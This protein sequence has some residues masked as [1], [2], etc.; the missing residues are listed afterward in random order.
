MG[1]EE[2]LSPMEEVTE[3]ELKLALQSFQKD[4]SPGLDGWTIEF[5][6]ELYD[7]LGD[8]ILKV[9]K[10]SHLSDSILACFNSTFIT[11]IPK[12]DNPKTLHDFKPISLCNCIYKVILKVIA[13]RLKDILS[14]HISVEQFGFLNG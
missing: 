13:R 8:E 4:K 11:L 12:M 14:E 1:E 2:N 7:L 5:F 10:L 3:E 6:T 9:V